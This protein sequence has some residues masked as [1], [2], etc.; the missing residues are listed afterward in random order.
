MGVRKAMDLALKVSREF[1]GPIYTYGPLIHNPSALESS[2]K[3][4]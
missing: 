1:P 4:A 3:R 2:R